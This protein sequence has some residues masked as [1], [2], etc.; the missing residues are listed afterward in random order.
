VNERGGAGVAGDGQSGHPAG[1]VTFLMTD[2]E[3]ST[4][5]WEGHPDVA[6]AVLTRRLEII[7]EATA[8]HGGIMPVE[9]GEGDSSVSVFVRA[10]DAAACAVDLQRRLASEPWP[11]DVDIRI[12]IALHTGEAHVRPDGTYQGSVLHRGA[13]LRSLAHGG[14]VLVSQATYELLADGTTD[15]GFLDAGV[16]QLRDLRRPEHVWQLSHPELRREFPPLASASARLGNVPAPITSFVGRER[17]VAEVTALVAER[18]LVTLTGAG[19]CGKTRLAVE[20]ARA[21]AHRFA[22]GVWWVDLAPLADGSLVGTTLATALG[23]AAPS[24][25]AT[26]DA[27]VSHLA[28]GQTLVVL[29][30]CEHLIAASAELTVRLTEG[31]PRATVLATSRELLGVPGETTWPVPPLSL[32][33]GDIESSEAVRLFVDR[34]SSLL[35]AFVLSDDIERSVAEVCTRLDGIPLAIEL[36]AS[37]IRAL[38][39]TQ[40]AEGLADR[41]RLLTG[42]GRSAL[43]RQRTLEGSV[44]W[45][46]DL[47]SLAEQAVFRRLSVFPGTFTLQAAEAVCAGDSV[48]SEDVLDLV[49]HL[50]DRS[51]VQVA[52]TA[53]AATRYRLLETIR[54]YG[55]HRLSA[56]GEASAVRD[57]HLEFSVSFVER[58]VAG[59][60]AG[61]SLTWLRAIDGEVDNLRAALDWSPESAHPEQGLTLVGML[62]PYLFVRGDLGIGR[63]RLEGTLRHAGDSG[64]RAD[65]LVALCMAAYKGGDMPKAREYADEAIAMARRLADPATLGR[66]LHFRAWVRCWGEGDRSGAWADFEEADALLRETPDVMFRGLNSALLG[67]SYADTSQAFRARPLVEEAL[68]VLSAT[69]GTQALAYACFAM[70][71]IDTLEG[72]VKEATGHL[73]QALEISIEVGD[74]YVEIFTRSVLAALAHVGGRIDEGRQHCDEGMSLALAHRIPAGE[75]SMRFTMAVYEHGRGN[76]DVAAAEIEAAFQCSPMRWFA[77]ICRER[78][79]EL[80]LARRD[81]EG[82]ARYAAEAL[83]LGRETDSVTATSGALRTLGTIARLDGDLHGAEDLLHEA[84]DLTHRVSFLPPLFE[85]VEA[86][87]GV[88]ADQGRLEEA[89]R[90]LGAAGTWRAATEYFRVNEDPTPLAAEVERLQE[91][92]GD[93]DLAAAWAEG[94]ALDV[95]DLVAYTRRGRGKRKRPTHGWASLTPTERQVVELVAEGL[96]NPQIG[97]RLF[98]S[99]RTVQTHLAHVFAKLGVSTRAEVAAEAARRHAPA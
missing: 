54:D 90:L 22:D 25:D 96:T 32:P 79:A 98:I 33:D 38:T 12:R 93:G 14:Q 77:A 37:R 20:V 74:P 46:H 51:L 1:T 66:A 67:W 69:A 16:H 43:P 24:P 71:W 88:V 63:A 81:R 87:A 50:V 48:A 4:R 49:S 3:G 55:R 34:A 39:A 85:T 17:E 82:A 94:A 7:A 44:A 9:Q 28:A 35:P 73:D 36:A 23:I 10:S 19:G 78:Q 58:A 45:S 29:D 59:M 56:S 53:G 91:A 95:D 8:E 92:L 80:A 40:I 68:D 30:N 57:R 84:L 86:L 27:V 2:V 41:F 42:G 61:E 26:V 13:R 60:Q 6:A 89:A 64:S 11:G 21:A 83:E 5:L 99:R 72:R 18:R 47:L 70:G 31:C 76:L 75:A 62:T 52:E 15:I 65:A 97:E